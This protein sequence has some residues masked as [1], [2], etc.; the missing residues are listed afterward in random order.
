MSMSNEVSSLRKPDKTNFFIR[1]LR[2][3]FPWKGDSGREVTR[4][5][6]FMMSVGMFAF[7]LGQLN[8]YMNISDDD[9]EYISEIQGYA[10]EFSEQ[11]DLTEN[12]ADDDSR[13]ENHREVQEWAKE[14]LAK[15]PNLV[16]YISID[17]F[18]NSAG[19]KYIDYPVVQYTDN[20]YYLKKNIYGDYYYSGSIYADYVVPID[21]TG[22]AQNIV[23]YGHNVRELGVMFTHLT[24]YK[25]SV[26]FLKKNPI[27]N[28]N[29]I[30]DEGERYVIFG[31]FV[32]TSNESQDNGNLFDYWR[33][34]NFDDGDYSFDKWIKGIK[35]R[36]WYSCDIELN[37]DDDY[38]TLSTCTN[39]AEDLRWVI[40]AKKITEK[41]DV[42]KIIGSYKAVPD[43]DIYFPKEWVDIWGNKPV[44]KGWLY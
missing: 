27:I 11:V 25:S 43:E 4:K 34:L 36:S 15:C 8:E 44:W 2:Y 24:E 5:I 3:I 18:L 30:Y 7:S 42:D 19:N 17:T 20:E 6:A 16:G 22:Q 14:L 9:L 23:L 38:L 37:P 33:F 12:K 21:E 26:D 35:A 13:P 32:S 28:F 41:D 39:E 29:T 40:V 1:F 10:P 31:C